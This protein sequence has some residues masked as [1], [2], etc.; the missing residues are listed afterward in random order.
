MELPVFH[1]SLWDAPLSH[2][3]GA[4]AAVCWHSHTTT[5]TACEDARDVRELVAILRW[6]ALPADRWSNI[7]VGI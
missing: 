5:C 7:D 1:R 2:D 6:C 3:L 4:A